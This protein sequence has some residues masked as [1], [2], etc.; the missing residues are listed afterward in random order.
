M[1]RVA[2]CSF[3]LSGV[4]L[5]E[6][7]LQFKHHL[8]ADILVLKLPCTRP[9]RRAKCFS[10]VTSYYCCCYQTCRRYAVHRQCQQQLPPSVQAFA[11]VSVINVSS[12]YP[13]RKR[14]LQ[15]GREFNRLETQ[16]VSE[17]DF[18][19]STNTH[20][21]RMQQAYVIVSAD[22]CYYNHTMQTD[23]TYISAYQ[24]HLSNAW[25]VFRDRCENDKLLSIDQQLVD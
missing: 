19:G 5:A 4:E 25:L 21:L 10:R 2:C 18:V 6:R 15:V 11:P 24:T 23:D 14:G 12:S 13:P 22:C 8:Q 16:H 3:Q 7:R 17:Q 9:K 20:E 1:R